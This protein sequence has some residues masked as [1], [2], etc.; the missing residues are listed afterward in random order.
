[1]PRKYGLRQSQYVYK[2]EREKYSNYRFSISE[3]E[4]HSLVNFL[5]SHFSISKPEI[6]F[7]KMVIFGN[8]KAW[9]SLITINR[10]TML[11]S[12]VVHEFTHHLAYQRDNFHG[13]TERFLSVLDEVYHA[14]S[15]YLK[16]KPT[17]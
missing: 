10:R 6:K 12:T 11:F 1:M 9:R 13:H 5:S 8:Y 4:V 7:R 17:P 2:I 16:Q 15:Q 3:S 14:A